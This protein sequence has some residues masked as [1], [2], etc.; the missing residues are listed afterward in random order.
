[1]IKVLFI[2]GSR[3]EYDLLFNTI[4]L[5]SS[6]KKYKCHLAI[7]G[8]HLSTKYGKSLKFIKKNRKIT[9]HKVNIMVNN[10]VSKSIANSMSN[11]IKKF[12]LLYKKI[13]PSIILVVGDRFEAFSAVTAAKL[14]LIPVVHFHGGETTLGAYDNYWRHC[15]SIMSN[16]H[17]VS[18]TLYKKKVDKITNNSSKS[19]VV[20]ALGIDNIKKIKFKNKT[21]LKKELKFHFNLNNILIVFHSLS[22]SPNLN[23]KYFTNLVKASRSIPNTNIFISYPG[24]DLG[25]DY[26]IEEIQK[27][28]RLKSNNIFIFKNLGMN[29][30]LSLLKVCDIILGNSSSGIFEAPYLNTLTINIG[31]RQQGRLIDKTVY[32]CNPDQLKIINKIKLLLRII[33]NKNK[34]KSKKIYGNGKASLRAFKIINN[35]D[36]KKL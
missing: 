19:Y 29:N 12:D 26:I 7:T 18:N 24:H 2:T 21:L 9:Y 25:S 31:N 33:K 1:M 5:F 20:G 4:N 11:T 13:K 8:S 36:L 34:P 35:V 30:F 14:N 23:K 22:K 3:S 15:I 27:L 28:K 16:I 6:S 17:F 32:N 10:S